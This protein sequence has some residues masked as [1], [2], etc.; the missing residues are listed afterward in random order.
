M[1]RVV[2]S[3]NKSVWQCVLYGVYVFAGSILYQ[4]KICTLFTCYHR[5]FDPTFGWLSH[6]GVGNL[7]HEFYTEEI[8]N[9]IHYT[10]YRIKTVRNKYSVK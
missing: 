5:T 7:S 9:T 3:G 4:R 2:R 1:Q 8:S 6:R 10:I